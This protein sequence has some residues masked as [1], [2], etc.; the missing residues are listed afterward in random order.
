M[1]KKNEMDQ[2]IIDEGKF[3][4]AINDGE[5]FKT[6]HGEAGRF[7]QG[8][9]VYFRQIFNYKFDN[10]FIINNR[11]KLLKLEIIKRKY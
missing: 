6:S 3:L 8:G 11:E 2:Y 4:L 10:E 9:S 5:V 1:E 7:R